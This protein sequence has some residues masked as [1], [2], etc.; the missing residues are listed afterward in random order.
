MSGALSRGMLNAFTAAGKLTP[1]PLF[2]SKRYRMLLKYR[3]PM[4]SDEKN[5]E[6]LRFTT[7]NPASEPFKGIVV[8]ASVSRI[9]PVLVNSPAINP[10]TVKSKAP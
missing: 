9:A 5:A 10:R 8:E 1:A 2:G 7:T 4:F 6:E 3:T